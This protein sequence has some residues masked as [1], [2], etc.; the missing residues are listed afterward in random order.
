MFGAFEGVVLT[1]VGTDGINR[2]VDW[3]DGNRWQPLNMPDGFGSY[4]SR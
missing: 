1:W 4:P 3:T 2:T